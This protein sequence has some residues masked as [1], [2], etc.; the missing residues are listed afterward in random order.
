MPSGTQVPS[1]VDRPADPSPGNGSSGPI[2]SASG[3]GSA[4]VR[5]TGL[6]R[7]VR[8]ARRRTAR[9]RA[10]PPPPRARA[11][12]GARPSSAERGRGH[13]EPAYGGPMVT[14]AYVPRS[15]PWPRDAVP[16]DTGHDHLTTDQRRATRRPHAAAARAPAAPCPTRSSTRCSPRSST[17]GS[18]PG[19]ALPSERRL[20]EVLGVSRPAVREA[21]QRMTQTRL[22]EVR[23]GGATTVRDFRSTPGSTCSRGCWSA[24]AR[25]TRPSPA[26][27]SRPGSRSARRRRPG[28]RA[29]RAGPRGDRSPTTVDALAATDDA[30]ERQSHA[31]DVL[32]P[33]SSTPP[34]RSCS[35]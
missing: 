23:H 30:V 12:A 32:G 1:T 27:S 10:A 14:V 11:P 31:L 26:A 22:L 34:T 19:E 21:L 17:A 4:R 15:T 29:R 24:A 35:G 25:S 13:V 9:A 8:P 18:R 33:A 7:A 28:R 6:G 2:T 5:S 20:A 3:T 16:V